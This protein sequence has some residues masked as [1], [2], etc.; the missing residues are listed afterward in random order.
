MASDICEKKVD[1]DRL[2]NF[3]CELG[4]RLIRN[5]A[6]IYRV[7]ES[8]S[9]VIHAYGYSDSEVFAIPSFIVTN[10]LVDGKN[11]SKMVKVRTAG[12]NL[13]R[14][15]GINDLCRKICSENIPIDEAEKKLREIV[16]MK[17]YPTAL[18]YAAYGVVAAF[19]TLFYG[20]SAL[21][22]V[23]SFF[24]GLVVKFVVSGTKKLKVNVFFSNIAASALLAV[25]PTLLSY[26]TS[27]IHLDKI[28][29]GAIMLLVPG[30]AIMNVVRDILAGDM[31]T[32]VTKFAEAM[33]VAVGIAIGIAIPIA[34]FRFIF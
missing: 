9:R 20:G 19:F 15:S 5:G 25:I 16:A 7:E 17:T 31:L 3:V 34:G 29:I 14:L 30:I 8:I 22:A 23:I 26:L 33:L 12:N 2:L 13:E 21:D 1:P 6:E 4:I 18:S 28:I 32:A 24:S 27:D 11:Y 10:I